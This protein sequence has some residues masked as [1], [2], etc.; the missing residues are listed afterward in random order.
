M[1]VDPQ[2]ETLRHRLAG[3]WQMPLLVFSIAALTAAV[4]RMRPEPV[5][6][7]FEEVYAR[8]ASLHEAALYTEASDY[9]EKLLADPILTPEEAGRLKLL[10]A[11]T[12]Y[13]FE[14]NNVIHGQGNAGRVV[15]HAAEAEAAGLTLDASSHQMC[16]VAL[17]W[18][19]RP[20]DA[21][22]RYDQAIALLPADDVGTWR[23]R[24]RALEIQQT[25]GGMEAG[26][27]HEALDTF[28]TSG[29]PDEE[30]RFWAAEQKVELYAR[31]D[32]HADAARFLAE[33]AAMFDQ[34]GFRADFAYLRSLSLYRVGQLDDA[35]RQLRQ[36][37]DWAESSGPGHRT[38]ARATWLLGKVLQAMEQ[39][40]T[41]LGFFDEVI[42]HASPGT[43]WTAA[44]LGRA[45]T[46]ASL[47]RFDESVTAYNEAVRLTTEQPY[48]SVVDLKVVREST[49]SL[50]Q[51]LLASGR[52]EQAMSYLTIAARLAPPGETPIQALFARRLGDLSFTLG[53]RAL[54]EGG[55]DS[56]PSADAGHA[57][58]IRR[59][60]QASDHYLRLAEL[61][62][63]AEPEY[64][65]A[66]WQAADA[67]DIAGDR[68]GS[69]AVLEGYVAHADASLSEALLPRALLRLGQTWQAVEDYE[70]AIHWYQ[71]NLLR[72]PRTP[73]AVS[74]LV[75]LAESFAASDKLTE[76]EH[77]LR[78]VLERSAGDPLSVITPS[79]AE[80]RDALYALAELYV[81]M[82]NYEAS[83]ARYEEALERYPGDPRTDR[84]VFVLADVYRRSA[85]QLRERMR[86]PA[87][88]VY[89]DQLKAARRSRLA[90]A[91]ALYGQVIERYADR[92][93]ERLSE[94][95]RFYLK[96][97]FLGQA[98]AVF[99]G[100]GASVGDQ[101]ALAECLRLYDQASFRFPED[102]IC[103]SAYVQ[104][105]NCHLRLGE[106][107]KARNALQRARWAL[108]QI[109][110]QAFDRHMPEENRAYWED[111]LGWL[112]R[113]PLL[114][115]TGITAAAASRPD[116]S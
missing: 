1:S 31:E 7:S 85:D 81:R 62:K 34:P 63:P 14:R 27:L 54:Q 112:E 88:A 114:A 40:E 109:P 90:R 24:R 99:D 43:Y 58:A 111:Y 38:Y 20:E 44:M 19:K 61:V 25:I 67:L 6:P 87:Q 60:H 71:E 108:R 52:L 95:E 103:L 115:P 94:L 84:G 80:Y 21:L 78:R 23:L 12:I 2:Q 93:P 41:A 28:L 57:D 68:K 73:S 46:L 113:T 30:L 4:W 55:R 53:R 10:L 33:S 65:N 89:A 98:D 104:M 32:R 79:A 102:P 47:E 3:H 100:A 51:V 42:R 86:D 45:E 50:Y 16:A 69:A 76:A 83:I 96:S 64:S 110:D 36:M 92:P 56:D 39:P 105:I 37:R 5:V 35:E 74:A 11:R 8:A 82:G 29:G 97:A 49:T 66:V 48:G 22:G 26:R 18:L 72:F 15:S 101:A 9:I 17:E 116:E 107:R 59:L 106:V 75:P 91:S 13:D 77:T 70:R